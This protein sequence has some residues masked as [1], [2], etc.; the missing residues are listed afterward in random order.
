[1]GYHIFDA[2]GDASFDVG[3]NGGELGLMDVGSCHEK[4]VK[5]RLGR[6]LWGLLVV[7]PGDGDC[8]IGLPD[9]GTHRS[10]RVDECA[11]EQV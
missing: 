9:C 2:V 5:H 10:G 8:R 7:C 6:E 3:G 1:M 4:N 11:R